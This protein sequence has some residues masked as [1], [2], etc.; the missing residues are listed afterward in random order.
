[1]SYEPTSQGE[2]RRKLCTF[3]YTE[4]TIPVRA[5]SSTSCSARHERASATYLPPAVWTPTTWNGYRLLDTPGVN[6]PIRHEEVTADQLA[7]TN[8]VVLVIREGDQ[9]VMDVY[10]RLFA[11]MKDKK[12]L[13]II[14]NHQLG[15]AD[16]VVMSS[17]RIGDIL[18]RLA[19]EYG[20]NPTEVEALPI[21]PMN[22]NT[23]LR[24]SMR[25]H[26]RLLEHSG[27]TRFVESFAD[28][29]RRRDNEHHHLSAIK[30]TVK[31]LWYDPVIR[32]LKEL[33]G[34]SDGGEAEELRVSER[35]L[36]GEKDRLHAA[37][38]T[39]VDS[40]VSRIR[41]DIGELIRNSGDREEADERL[42]YVLQPLLERINR[43]LNEELSGGST[44][45]TVSVEA[46]E[47]SEELGK[48]ERGYEI[49]RC[50]T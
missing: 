9:D 22:L 16:E 33:T 23:A 2:S 17:K 7:R 31:S 15:S 8:A 42:K 49:P 14:L 13:F 48:L 34:A 18:S 41:S 3:S 45:T 44:N 4:P 6:A 1:M 29:A 40:E 26:A 37:A 11:M 35:T 39:M 28:W 21:Y 47:I 38:Y 30:D 20:V 36:I 32:R 43:W 12:A 5:R 24:G 46:P 19:A 27:F 25:R 10:N 50:E